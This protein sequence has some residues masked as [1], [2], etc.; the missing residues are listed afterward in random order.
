MA[1]FFSLPRR[2]LMGVA[3][4]FATASFVYGTVWVFFEEPQASLGTILLEQPP[5][6]FPTITQVTKGSPADEA[7]QLGLRSF[8]QNSVRSATR[9]DA[10]AATRSSS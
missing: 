9:D 5:R 4:L 6:P 8:H 2:V 1:S 3:V 7:G 10:L